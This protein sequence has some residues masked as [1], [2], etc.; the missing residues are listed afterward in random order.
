[1]GQLLDAL[2]SDG[3]DVA[4]QCES[5]SAF[6]LDHQTDL[7]RLRFSLFLS[8]KRFADALAVD[9][10]GYLPADPAAAICQLVHRV[11]FGFG[12]PYLAKLIKPYFCKCFTEGCQSG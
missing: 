7:S 2:G 12:L 5:S 6:V 1:M 10:T 3:A 4:G 9:H 11:Q 8:R